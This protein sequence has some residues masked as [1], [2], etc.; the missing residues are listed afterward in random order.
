MRWLT[1]VDHKRIGILYICGSFLFFVAAGIMALLMRTQLAGANQDLLTEDGYN[2]VLT[3]HGTAMVFLFAMPML[4][5]FANYLVPLMIGA[6]DMAFPRLN[7][8]SLWLFFISAVVLIGS[9]GAEGGAGQLRLDGLRAALGG[10]LQSRRRPGPLDPGPAPD[11][12]LVPPQSDQLPRDDHEHA[13]AGD[14]LDADAAVRLVDRG[15]GDSDRPDR[16]GDRRALLLSCSTAR[17]EP[18]S[19][20][21][22]RRQRASSTSTCSGSSR[23]PRSTSSSCR[24]SG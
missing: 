23:I 21:P 1:T 4:A 7:A 5:G 16:A 3:M 17:R 10:S 2:G 15:A 22:R 11:W 14:D 20:C 12:R 8:V 6:R 13:R 24:R 18:T 19:S 9:F